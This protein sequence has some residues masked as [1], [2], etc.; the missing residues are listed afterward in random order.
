M[1]Q[2][3]SVAA[4]IRT[5]RS[6]TYRVLAYS[7]QSSLLDAIQVAAPAGWDLTL[8]VTPDAAIQELRMRHIDALITDEPALVLVINDD[9]PGEEARNV[10]ISHFFKNDYGYIEFLRE[11]REHYK[12]ISEVSE[13][14]LPIVLLILSSKRKGPPFLAEAT[15][16]VR[17]VIEY[18]GSNGAQLAVIAVNQ[19]FGAKGNLDDAVE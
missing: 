18:K 13:E 6:T 2:S 14:R 15:G 1:I 10:V 3:D 8:A 11:Y 12:E 9:L 17:K 7:G 4:E 5:A 16:Q 19:V